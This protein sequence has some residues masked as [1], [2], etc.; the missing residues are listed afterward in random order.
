MIWLSRRVRSTFVK[1]GMVG[2]SLPGRRIISPCA[3]IF[4]VENGVKLQRGA[5][6]CFANT[7]AIECDSHAAV[8]RETEFRVPHNHLIFIQ[9]GLRLLPS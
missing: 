2:R 9:Q 8:G 7:S 4:A 5:P 1:F 3:N 6:T